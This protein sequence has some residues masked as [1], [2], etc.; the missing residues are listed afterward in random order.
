MSSD[1]ETS[2]ICSLDGNSET[3]SLDTFH[4]VI[5]S[6]S[7][8]ADAVYQGRQTKNS[9]NHKDAVITMEE[10][11]HISSSRKQGNFHLSNIHRMVWVGRDLKDHL[12]SAPLPCPC[13]Y[14]L[15]QEKIL[16]NKFRFPLHAEV[17]IGSR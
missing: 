8:A 3:S 5:F 16:H 10:I 11:F 7:R 2:W 9:S 12:V 4:Q 13:S 6:D 1:A 14:P 17:C 15:H